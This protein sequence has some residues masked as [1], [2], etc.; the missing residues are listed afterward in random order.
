M[1]IK[2]D[3]LVVLPLFMSLNYLLFLSSEPVCPNLHQYN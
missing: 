3:P 2:M 1:T